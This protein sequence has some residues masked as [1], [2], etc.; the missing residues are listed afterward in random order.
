[1]ASAG[2][3][4]ASLDSPAWRP[5]GEALLGMVNA[6]SNAKR[7]GWLDPDERLRQAPHLR[8]A[9]HA[10]EPLA[11]SNRQG[12]PHVHENGLKSGNGSFPG[13]FA[14]PACQLEM[15]SNTPAEIRV[16]AISNVQLVH[17]LRGT[18]SAGRRRP[19]RAV[20]VPSRA[21]MGL[22]GD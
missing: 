4:G 8:L 17:P 19:V 22:T 7:Q 2:S 12:R 20:G 5:L 1:M 16:S 9:Q 18:A 10:N 15:I 21:R 3:N 14:F 13:L 6:A 11:M